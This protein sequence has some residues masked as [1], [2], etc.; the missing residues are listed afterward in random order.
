VVHVRVEAPQHVDDIVITFADSH[1]TYI[2]AKENIRVADEAWEKL[3]S[4]FENQFLSTDFALGRDRLLFHTGE[5][6]SEYLA[7]REI[8]KRAAGLENHGEWMTAL[9]TEQT[10]L[11]RKR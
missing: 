5:I 8:C 1:K 2:H 6:R 11:L 4:D 7:L 3:W 9:N 10:S